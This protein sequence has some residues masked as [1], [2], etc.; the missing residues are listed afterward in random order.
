MSLCS[1]L[2]CLAG[3]DPAMWGRAAAS[4]QN[5]AIASCFFERITDLLARR[6][7]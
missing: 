3:G 7:V 6:Q 4:S 5:E 2:V 1:A